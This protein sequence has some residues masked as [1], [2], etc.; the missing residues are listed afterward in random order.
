MI[1]YYTVSLNF[2]PPQIFPNLIH[3]DTWDNI[4]EM[5]YGEP[6]GFLEKGSDIKGILKGADSSLDY[7]A[8]VCDSLF[9]M[10]STNFSIDWSNSMA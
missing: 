9:H 2:R 1:G 7:F 4:A 6:L 3:L 10:M 5:T 8:T